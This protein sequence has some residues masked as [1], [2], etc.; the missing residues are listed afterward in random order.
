MSTITENRCRIQASKQSGA[1]R[2][3]EDMKEVI[4]LLV[5]S[6]CNG[7]GTPLVALLRA[8]LDFNRHSEFFHILIDHTIVY[9]IS[10]QSNELC[11][12]LLI[13]ARYPNSIQHMRDMAG[14][15]EY[16]KHIF[17]SFYWKTFLSYAT[18]V[19]LTGTPCQSISRAAGMTKRK[20][21][22]LHAQPSNVWHL[23]HSGIVVVAT[24]IGTDRLLVFAENVIPFNA[25]D[26]RHL[27]LTA[28]FRS[29]LEPMKHDGNTRPRYAWTSVLI[30]GK[31]QR[32]EG[33]QDLFQLPEGWK[34]NMQYAFPTLRAIFPWL[35]WQ[36]SQD[37]TDL[38]DQDRNTVQSCFMLSPEGLRLPS[39]SIWIQL[40]GFS[41]DLNL[42]IQSSLPCLHKVQFFNSFFGYTKEACGLHC[43]CENWSIILQAL[44]EGW[45]LQMSTRF[46]RHMF[47]C[48][49]GT[50]EDSVRRFDYLHSKPAHVCSDSC[51][52]RRAKP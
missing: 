10:A 36:W 22:G 42:A 41:K 20:W 9:E 3:I 48:Q 33:E 13:A 2:S 45:N 30:S 6:L 28:G 25:L 34:F 23:A 32:L 50:K 4:H 47:Q 51:P 27:D 18:V 49:Y 31:M 14:F 12:Q 46:I 19:I 16:A 35:F 7:I 37:P 44:G 1:L 21:F 15:P 29:N 11:K 8:V 39:I 38:T 43:Y 24:H 5:F 40:M 17:Q 52:E 26:L